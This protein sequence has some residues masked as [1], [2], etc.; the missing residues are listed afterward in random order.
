MTNRLLLSLFLRSKPLTD[1]SV[2]KLSIM[3]PTNRIKSLIDPFI[4]VSRYSCS[5]FELNFSL[6]KYQIKLLVCLQIEMI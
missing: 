6:F 3:V 4:F 2:D 1:L 5:L